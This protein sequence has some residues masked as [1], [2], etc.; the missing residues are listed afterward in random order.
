[1]SVE[2]IYVGDPMCSWCWGFHPVLMAVKKALPEE[3]E[4]MYVMGGLARDSDE[5][6]PEETR[7]YVQGAW[8]SVAERTGATFNW[9]FW[10]KCEPRRC[11]YPACRA[12]YAAMVQDDAAGIAMYEA[13]QKAYYHEARNPSD[14]STLIELAGEITPVLDRDRF[15]KDLVS[16]EIEQMLQDGFN[17]RRSMN[18]NQFPS[19]IVRDEE[20]TTFVTTGFDDVEPVLARLESTLEAKVSA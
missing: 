11:T 10:E 7:G 4:V 9:D 1:M 16:E 13:I 12:Y 2:I 5:A 17:V 3:L 20:S 15:A 19:L 8:R 18:A 14:I 6:M